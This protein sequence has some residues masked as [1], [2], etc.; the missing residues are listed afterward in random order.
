MATPSWV[1]TCGLSM[2]RVIVFKDILF[3]NKN[4]KIKIHVWSSTNVGFCPKTSMRLA[5]ATKQN[6]SC[7]YIRQ[8]PHSP[9]KRTQ[10]RKKEQSGKPQKTKTA[11]T[12]F[13]PLQTCPNGH[14]MIPPFFSSP[15]YF[16]IELGLNG[17]LVLF[18]QIFMQA[19]S[20]RKDR[21]GFVLTWNTWA[22]PVTDIATPNWV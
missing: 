22:I 16:S 5:Q 14:I 9:E 3:E 17:P 15:N 19:P 4:N 7:V 6:V 2:V 12:R 13:L 18:G 10:K 1:Y 21:C 11:H 20:R 8:S